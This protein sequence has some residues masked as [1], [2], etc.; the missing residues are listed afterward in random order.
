MSSC[1]GTR[2]CEEEWRNQIA[3][4]IARSLKLPVIATNGVRYASAYDREILDIFTAIR[5][6]TKLDQAGRLL[7]CNHQRYLR[8]AREMCALFHNV[9]GA[10]ENTV[11]LSSRLTFELSDLGYKFPCYP[12]PDGETMDSFLRKRVAEG[13]Q[14]RYGPKNNRALLKR[15]KDQAEYELALIEKLGFAGY[16]LI[17]WNIVDYCKRDGILI[18]GRGSAANSATLLKSLPL[19]RSEW[20]CSSSAF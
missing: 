7:S 19:I 16:F 3:H 2:S 9:P 8:S 5:H 1:S 15:A 13:V 11:H 17:V 12:V 14:R 20:I 4:R 10:I 18:Q 6:H